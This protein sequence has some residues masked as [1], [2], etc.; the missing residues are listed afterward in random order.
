MEWFSIA[1]DR[2]FFMN[3]HKLG[4]NPLDAFNGHIG[5]VDIWDSNQSGHFHRREGIGMIIPFTLINLSFPFLE[6]KGGKY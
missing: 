1:G 6:R 4:C 3:I 5:L 2:G